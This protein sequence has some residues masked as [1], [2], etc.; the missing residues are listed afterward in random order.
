MI[1]VEA[2]PSGYIERP[3]EHKAVVDALLNRSGAQTVA[4]TTA[5]RGAG[6]FGKTWLAR[7]ICH[8]PRVQAAFPDGVY[9][10]TIGHHPIGQPS[11]RS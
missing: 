8:D 4:I 5:L 2:K 11:P 7:A 9:W 3:A 1:S 6:G 10:L